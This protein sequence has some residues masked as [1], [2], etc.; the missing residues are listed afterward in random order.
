MKLNLL[1]LYAGIALACCLF[2]LL[3]YNLMLPSFILY[4]LANISGIYLSL[5]AEDELFS[6]IFIKTSALLSFIP[7][8]LHGMKACSNTAMLVLFLAIFYLVFFDSLT[9]TLFQKNS[10]KPL[11]AV[12]AN[13]AIIVPNTIMVCSFVFFGKNS[14]NSFILIILPIL[15]YYMTILFYIFLNRKKFHKLYLMNKEKKPWKEQ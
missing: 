7:F 14:S 5:R 2:I 11:F 12:K 15:L 8:L 4:M 13:M 9:Y 3:H 10:I 1:M 6:L